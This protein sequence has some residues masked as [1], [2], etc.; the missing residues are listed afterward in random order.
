MLQKIVRK[1][2]GETPAKKRNAD[3]KG[4]PSPPDRG[5]LACKRLYATANE[6]G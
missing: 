3:A 6:R 4:S 1:I 5:R 2:A